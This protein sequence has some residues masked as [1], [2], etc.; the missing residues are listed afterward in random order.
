M[1]KGTDRL[2]SIS[3][4]SA[5]KSSSVSGKHSAMAHSN[6]HHDDSNHQGSQ[7]NQV[8]L[9]REQLDQFVVTALG[10]GR[11]KD[12]DHATVIKEKF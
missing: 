5:D 11:N 4:I 10:G 1:G 2:N 9:L 7:T 12:D 8:Q 6:T 3:F